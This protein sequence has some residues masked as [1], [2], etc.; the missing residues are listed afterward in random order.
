MEY[1]IDRLRVLFKKSDVNV[2]DNWDVAGLKGSGSNDYS[3]KEV[4]VPSELTWDSTQE[5]VRGGN[6]TISGDPLLWYLGMLELL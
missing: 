1:V 5:S 3:V 6:C 2:L 4:Y